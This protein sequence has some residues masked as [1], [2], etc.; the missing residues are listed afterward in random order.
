MTLKYLSRGIGYLLDG[1]L[2]RRLALGWHHYV[3]RRRLAWWESQVG[4]R[5][6]VDV[7]VQDGV[8]M[9]LHVDSHISRHIYAGYL[10]QGEREFLNTF[11]KSGDVFVDVGANAGLYT[12]IAAHRVGEGGSVYA[13]EPCPATH[14]RLVENVQLNGLA[15]VECHQL[16]LSDREGVAEMYVSKDGF[17]A[18]NSLSEPDAPGTFAPEAV[19][20]ITWDSFAEGHNLGG[21]VTMMKIDV[22]GWEWRVLR[23][24]RKT[25]SR[26]DAPVLQLEFY[27]QALQSA[28]SSCQELYRLLE[29]LGYQLFVYNPYSKKT[30]REPLRDAY[31]SRV[32]LIAARHEGHLRVRR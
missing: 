25:L 21:R 28:G 24:G 26:P 32:N 19:K 10:E 16:A 6:W 1:T 7:K 13:F 31:P 3:G 20:S 18:Q 14:Q 11:L 23:G 2:P 29:D 12:L 4:R 27:D 5:D 30:V 22:E 15:N 9:R 8:R 17:D